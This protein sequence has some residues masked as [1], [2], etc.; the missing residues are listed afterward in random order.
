MATN[1][2]RIDFEILA[3]L[4]EEGRLSN[5]ELAA[6]VDLAPSTCLERVRKLHDEGVLEGYHAQVNP[7][8]LGIRLQAM[9]AVRLQKHSR[10]LVGEF[11][12]Y[13]LSLPEVLST[14]HVTGEHDFLIHVAV[15]D[16]EHLRDLA[17]DRF[18]TRPEVDQLETS[19]IFE[20][21]RTW[22]LPNLVER[23]DE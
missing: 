1:L 17:L 7:K 19:L 22:Q 9:I 8:A 20:H 10:D 23:D 5:K 13:V 12:S 14:F 2:D 16:A 18:T 6:R 21:A 4:Q 15:R 3:A 11:R